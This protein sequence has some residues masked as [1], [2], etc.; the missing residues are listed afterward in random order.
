VVIH[1]VPYFTEVRGQQKSLVSKDF[2]QEDPSFGH[3][4]RGLLIDRVIEL[5]VLIAA[6]D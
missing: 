2:I 3:S 6:I 1:S 4:T 5:E